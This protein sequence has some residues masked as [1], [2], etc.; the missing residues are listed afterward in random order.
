MIP[1]VFMSS[2]YSL[3]KGLILDRSLR[4]WIGPFLGIAFR[5]CQRISA[6]RLCVVTHLWVL[7]NPPDSCCLVL[8]AVRDER[9]ISPPP[10]GE[11][12]GHSPRY[13]VFPDDEQLVGHVHDGYV[14]L[15]CCE[16]VVWKRGSGSTGKNV[17]RVRVEDVGH[18]LGEILRCNIS[19]CC[20]WLGASVG[21]GSQPQVSSACS[22]SS[23]TLQ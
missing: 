15:A 9:S 23:R 11:L 3:D 18:P 13:G 21:S 12:I 16:D 20:A 1:R 22:M 4:F 6:K 8:M 10:A 14:C 19:N 2:R 17:E 7:G 5:V